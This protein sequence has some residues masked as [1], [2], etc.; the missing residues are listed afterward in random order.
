MGVGLCL[1]VPAEAEAGVTAALE[2]LGEKP[3]RMGECV[4]GSGKVVYSDER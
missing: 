1:I 2:E 4:E 3:F